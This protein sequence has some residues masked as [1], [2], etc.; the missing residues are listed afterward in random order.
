MRSWEEKPHSAWKVPEF[1]SNPRPPEGDDQAAE[2]LAMGADRP[3]R[4]TDTSVNACLVPGTLCPQAWLL[5]QQ[6]SLDCPRRDREG[7]G[8]WGR[9]DLDGL[10]GSG[11]RRGLRG[12]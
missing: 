10:E 1:C 4:M 2:G 6:M 8:P 11:W 5:Q 12:V 9:K 3:G 7:W